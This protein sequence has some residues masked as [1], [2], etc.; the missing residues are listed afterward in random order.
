MIKI[1]FHIN[2]FLVGGIEKTLLQ[3]I[4]FLQPPHFD[5]TLLISHDLG[6]L[7]KLRSE[8]PNH[9][10]VEHLLTSPAILWTKKLKAQGRLPK[11]F[12]IYDELLQPI[13][14][15]QQ[16]K[17]L[18]EI[19]QNIDVLVDFDLT[20]GSHFHKITCKKIGWLHFS[21]D[22]YHRGNQRKLQR[23]GVK[24]KGYDK[25]VM[26][27]DAMLERARQ[28]YPHL[29]DKLIRVY[30]SLDR[31]ALYEKQKDLSDILPSERS[32][33]KRSY[34]FSA[35][36][37]EESQKDFT[38]LLKA[39]AQISWKIP[40]DLVIAGD[41]R[42]RPQLEALAK[43]L[44]I[45]QRVHFLGFKR[46]CYVWLDRCD[47]FVLSSHFEGLPTVLIEALMFKKKIVATDCPTG[48]REILAG[49]KC[50]QLVPIKSPE[51]MAEA[52]LTACT[53]PGPFDLQALE[54]HS[55]NFDKSMA[56]KALQEIYQ[57]SA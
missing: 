15:K 51:K 19:A 14:K 44:G 22:H 6:D 31:E 17:R 4:S 34:I 36:R 7:E 3:Q 54:Q 16:K 46:N 18:A 50:G 53:N 2:T 9:V 25:V 42:H 52:L 48:P 13:R 12:K 28:I 10:H 21:P 24:L 27:S 30:N 47:V 57:P 40:Q 5:V 33:L 41:G 56:I 8:I 37:L 29:S 38:T 1:A 20:L 11:V 55:R 35:A 43:N 32:L 23:L 49:G 26:I 45:S 39:Y